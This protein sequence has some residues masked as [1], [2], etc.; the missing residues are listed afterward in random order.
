[1]ANLASRRSLASILS[2]A[3]SSSSP[4][5]SS[6]SLSSR[7]RFASALPDKSSP[8][9]PKEQPPAQGDDHARRLRLRALVNR[10]G[11]SQRPKTFR[12]RDD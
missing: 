8:A 9:R 5:T 10:D 6:P 4:S 7:S 3:L 11:V 12:G 2:R 1:M